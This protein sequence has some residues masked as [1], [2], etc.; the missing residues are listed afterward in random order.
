M[1]TR[2]HWIATL[3]AVP[4]GLLSAAPK[5]FWENRDPASWTADEKLAL[6]SQSP[7]AQ[8]GVAEFDPNK[9]RR[10]KV[11]YGNDGRI[12]NNMPS[13]KPN[14]R[15]G[16]DMSAPIGEEIPPA[17]NPHPGEVV[18]FSILA[19]WETAEPVRLANTLVLPEMSEQVYI[20]SLRG[21][22][23]MPPPKVKR[24]QEPPPDPNIGILQSVRN[25]SRLVRK[26]RAPIPCTKLFAGK[27]EAAK[28]V[29][30]VFPR[31]LDNAIT[32][33]DRIV[34]FECNFSPYE[35]SIKFTLKDMKFKGVLTL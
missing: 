9:K 33:A 2:R 19:R 32:E 16:G 24:G 3:G 17:P 31:D 20:L 8:G 11:G 1:L 18:R 34:Y 6:L 28:E 14:S 7:W 10:S 15:I 22:P 25:G 35:L 23:L 30:L 12:G 4:G 21:L 5:A 29:L 27:G 26:D 13:G